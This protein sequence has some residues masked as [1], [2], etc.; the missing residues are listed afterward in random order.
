VNDEQWMTSGPDHVASVVQMKE[1]ALS[2]A[3][4]NGH[5][6]TVKHL[7]E[8]GGDVNALDLVWAMIIAMIPFI[9]RAVQSN[10]LQTVDHP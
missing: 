8:Q 4:H 5:F 10:L 9:R 3:A 1:T 2:R 6:F 7:I